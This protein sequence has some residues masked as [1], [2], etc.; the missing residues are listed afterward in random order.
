MQ[1]IA[2]AVI[3][4]P[5][6]PQ[7]AAAAKRLCESLEG[8]AYAEHS[9]V[10]HGPGPEHCSVWSNKAWDWALKTGADRFLLIQEDAV[11]APRF[12]PKF[13]AMIEAVPDE[14]IAMQV[15]HPIAPHLARL[16]CNW[17]ATLD[18]M[19]G[20]AWSCTMKTL[21]DFMR[22]KVEE[23]RP[24]CDKRVNEDTL[25]ALY[26]AA[27]R[28]PIWH[29]IPTLSDHDS[30]LPSLVGHDQHTN[31]N[32]LVTWRHVTSDGDGLAGLEDARWWAPR[33]PLVKSGKEA[34]PIPYVGRFYDA[35]PYLYMRWV[36]DWK[37]DEADRIECD[38]VRFSQTPPP[39]LGGLQVKSVEVEVVDN[40]PPT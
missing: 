35:T 7:R 16:G 6:H 4:C 15:I 33:N 26:C 36:K 32:S 18:A 17:F 22:W 5:W 34:L 40:A 9:E 39:S 38:L 3:A 37:E 28:I 8:E 14:V 11:V 20:V 19:P 12:W 10:I 13:R 24:G 1:T 31:R 25:F 2:L 27:H 30:E 29:P 21:A 23:L